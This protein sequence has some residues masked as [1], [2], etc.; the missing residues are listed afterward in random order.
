MDSIY[1]QVAAK[2]NLPK[3]QVAAIYKLYCSYLK[4]RIRN[5]NVGEEE[6]SLNL[7]RLGKIYFNKNKVSR[8]NEAKYKEN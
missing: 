5:I 3:T 1:K 6:I 7:T 2:L 8:K 4:E